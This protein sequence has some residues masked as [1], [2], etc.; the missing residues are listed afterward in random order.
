MAVIVFHLLALFSFNLAQAKCQIEVQ[1]DKEL[2]ITHTSVIDS[3]QARTGALSFAS[4]FKKF[5]RS[6]NVSHE[7]IQIQNW[8]NQ[9]HQDT[10]PSG[11][12]TLARSTAMFQWNWA[13]LSPE[14]APFILSAVVF[15]PDL[16][17]DYSE[18][19]LRLIFNL[20]DHV[21]HAEGFTAIFEF[22]L[23]R[24][25][26]LSWKDEFHQLA[27][28]DF[29][30]AFNAK[31]IKLLSMATDGRLRTNDFFLA[32]TWDLREFTVNEITGSI[33]QSVLPQTPDIFWNQSEDARQSLVRWIEENR[34]AILSG[35]WTLPKQFSTGNALTPNEGFKWL[36]RADLENDL[37]HKFS[38]HTCN[39]CHAGE[40]RTRFTHVDSRAWMV[41]PVISPFL[42]SDVLIR[43]SIF[44]AQLCGDTVRAHQIL[45]TRQGLIH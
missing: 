36:A 17:N 39:G 40:T 4:V 15:R 21:G 3:A 12:P 41:K 26:Q 8:L 24:F 33:E 42:K 20:I 22:Q 13:D 19:E 44:E 28:Q 34:D 7:K 9:W 38:L 18:G 43:K 25:N 2:L 27:L 14:S 5:S 23:P 29:G 11:I 45:T 16:A 30:P 10:L 37:R 1:P 35:L 31:L 6:E 32:P